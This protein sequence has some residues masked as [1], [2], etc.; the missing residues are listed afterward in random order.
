MKHLKITVR[1]RVQGVWYR[2]SAEKKAQEL[3][4]KGFAQ[5]LPNG[6]VYIEAEGPEPP[7]LALVCWC[8]EGPL[9]ARVDEVHTEEG[10]VVGYADFTVRR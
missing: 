7:L 3:G 6:E 5:N 8:H 1:G 10:A 9:L 4:L 2:A